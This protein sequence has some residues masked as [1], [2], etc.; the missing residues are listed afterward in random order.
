MNSTYN[1]GVNKSFN[2]QTEN[3]SQMRLRVKN[4]GWDSASEGIYTRFAELL[5]QFEPNTIEAIA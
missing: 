1:G 2:A 3:S 5:S 4:Y